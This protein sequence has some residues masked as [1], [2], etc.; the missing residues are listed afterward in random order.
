[1]NALAADR[2]P[3]V[4]RYGSRV[5]LLA[6]CAIAACLGLGGA[7][8]AAAPEHAVEVSTLTPDYVIPGKTMLIIVSVQNTGTQALE[9]TLAVRYR[10]PDGVEPAAAENLTPS[11]LSCQAAGQVEECLVDAS[12]TPSGSQIR[13][14]TIATVEAGAAG[15]LPGGEIRVS[16]GGVPGTFSEAFSLA[17]ETNRPFAIRG[18][19]V[20]STDGP[21]FPANDAGGH[22]ASLY[23]NLSLLSE[24]QTNFD[25]PRFVTD[26]PNESIRNVVVHVPPGLIGN[27]NATP[28]QCTAPQLE[29]RFPHTVMP[30]CPL[31]SQ[32]GVVQ[33][34]AQDIVGLFSVEPPPGYPAEFGFTYQTVVVKLLARIRPADN[35][36]DII[37]QQT[38]SSIPLPRTKVTFWGVPADP[39]HDH[40]RGLCLNG[41]FGYNAEES[42]AFSSPRVPFLR[43]PTSCPGTPLPWRIEMDTYQHPGTYVGKD[44]ASPPMEGCENLPFDPSLAA[45]PGGR[46]ARSPQSFNVSLTLPQ[47]SGPDGLAEADLRTADVTLPQGVTINPASADGLLACSDAQLRLGLEGPSECPDASELGSIELQTPLL[48]HPIEGSVFLRSQASS[49]P[50]S[51]DLFR[52]AIELRS[53]RDG[54]A[55]KLPG[56]LVVNPETGQMTTRFAELPQLPFESMQL[57]FKEGPRAPLSTPSTCGTYTTHAVF[58][59][60]SGK[61]VP[62]DSAFSIDQGCD[63]A[64]FKPGF[65]AGVANSTAGDFSPFLLR[66]TRDAGQPNLSRIDATLP[67]GEVA[68]LAGVPVCS[69]AQAAGGTCP[70]GSR[71]G[72]VVTG[73]GEGSSP[74]Y[75]PQPGKSPTSVYLAGPYKGAPYSVLAEV[76]AQAGPFDLGRVL[77]RSALAIDPES[78]QVSVKSDPLPQIFAGIPVSYRDVRV[79]IDRPEFTLNPTDCEPQ[80]VRGTIGSIAGSSAAVSDRFQVG[81]CASLGFKPRLSITLEGKARRAGHPALTAVLRM[82][83]G[84]ANIARTSVALPRSELL[85]QEHLDTSCTRVQYSAGAGGGEGCPKGSVYGH[86]RA[87]S[88]LLDRPLEGPVYLRSNGGDR[89]LPDLVASLGGQIHVDLVGYIDTDKRTR[90]L[91]TT[92]A[93]V[94]DAPVSKFV[95]K[96]PGGKKSLLANTTDICQGKHRAVVKMG[97]QNGKVQNFRPLVTVKCGKGA[98]AS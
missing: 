2:R 22:P 98:H 12:G 4:Q 95:L 78:V 96:L 92:F 39:S 13:L 93:K 79:E 57:H 84:G 90:G 38:P 61:T 75:L 21:T 43:N 5:V 73:I 34:D 51:G 9:G 50:A 67:E 49:D 37:S 60:W 19:E 83:K 16:G 6:L 7:E 20:G 30:Q 24:A 77:V 36:I 25:V 40:L 27:P 53:D 76:P 80:S 29:T 69:G 17:A 59:S 15:S 47:E 70:G 28:V 87:F 66:V 33:I 11:A 26:A 63:G 54:I 74:L 32:V 86:A 1:M 71:I 44:T 46:A 41:G 45:S 55:I 3:E 42:C 23:T 94:P 48:D 31:E 65:E 82:P 81:D 91:R 10:F 68:K 8:A 18:F 88:P 97:A 52:L 58:T 56:S 35:G 89:A 64:A 72:Q 85:A 14:K 62:Y